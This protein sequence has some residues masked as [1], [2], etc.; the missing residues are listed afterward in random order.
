MEIYQN[1]W[2]KA[3]AVLRGKFTSVNAYIKKKNNFK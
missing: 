1:L 3:K 2:Y